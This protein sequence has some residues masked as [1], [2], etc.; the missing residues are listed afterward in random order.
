MKA[1]RRGPSSAQSG[2][3]ISCEG[4]SGARTDRTEKVEMVEAEVDEFAQPLCDLG[5]GAAD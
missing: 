4:G 1:V 5:C 2:H 3:D